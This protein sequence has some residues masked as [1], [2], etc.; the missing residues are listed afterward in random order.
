[1]EKPDIVLIHDAVR[2][3]LSP[4][5]ILNNLDAAIESG[6]ADTCISSADTLV[7]APDGDWIGS[8][9]NRSDQ[10]EPGP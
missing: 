2:P 6:A 7:H 1:M 4:S 9:P 3:F 10:L 8:I 5:I